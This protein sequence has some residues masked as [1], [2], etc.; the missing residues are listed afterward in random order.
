MLSCKIMGACAR[1]NK[2]FSYKLRGKERAKDS[3]DMSN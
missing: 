1:L 3:G 2:I